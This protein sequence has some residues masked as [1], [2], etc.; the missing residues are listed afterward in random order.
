MT[1]LVGK[2]LGLHRWAWLGIAG[3]A[4]VAGYFWLQ[5]REEAD[6]RRNQE[7]GAQQQ[8]E[9]D[10]RET[11]ERTEQGNEARNEIRNDVGDA[12]YNQCLRSARTPENC[13]RF[14][15]E[16]PADND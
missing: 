6:D 4:L 7:I 13:K 10:L 14:L 8:R 1:W 2:F 5:S 15:P 12:R 11:L 3:A 16:R 9:G